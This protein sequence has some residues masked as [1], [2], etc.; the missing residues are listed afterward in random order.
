[1]GVGV[2]VKGFILYQIKYFY[3]IL[4]IYNNTITFY[5]IMFFYLAFKGAFLFVKY[6]G[7]VVTYESGDTATIQNIYEQ[8]KNKTK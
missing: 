1:M 2:G 7:E 8:L 4:N 6:G 5:F 3:I